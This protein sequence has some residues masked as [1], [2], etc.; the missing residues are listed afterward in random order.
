[1]NKQKYLDI[2]KE[3]DKD[4]AFVG[5]LKAFIDTY[6]GT[7]EA[8]MDRLIVS[9]VMLLMATEGLKIRAQGYDA[10]EAHNDNVKAK[11]DD[12]KEKY[13]KVQK[14]EDINEDMDSSDKE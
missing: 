8:E 4:S 14:G 6:D 1:M 11:I 3:F 7:N 13:N 5:N 2:L 10:L 9:I 12:I